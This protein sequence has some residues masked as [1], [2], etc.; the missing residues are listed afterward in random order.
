MS[1][2]LQDVDID[3]NFFNDNFIGLNHGQTI[4]SV[5]D[6]KKFNNEF[7]HDFSNQDL[8]IIHLNIRSLPRNGNNFIAYLDM[9]K[10]NFKIICLSETWLNENR[11]IDDLFSDYNAYHSMR[12]IDKSPGGGSQ[13]LFTRI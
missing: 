10:V 9:L 6:S 4:D 8:S 7:A 11:L 5:Y 12:K 1:S 2:V 3:S 13:Y